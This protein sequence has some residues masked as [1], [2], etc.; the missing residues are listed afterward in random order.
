ML[1]LIYA[2]NSKQL[3]AVEDHQMETEG[4]EMEPGN[5]QEVCDQ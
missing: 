2:V 4:L 1:E 5:E 3:Q